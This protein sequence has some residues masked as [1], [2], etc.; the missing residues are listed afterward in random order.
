MRHDVESIGGISSAVYEVTALGV[1]RAATRIYLREMLRVNRPKYWGISENLQPHRH[2][3]LMPARG[4]LGYQIHPVILTR[5]HAPCRVAEVERAA[6]APRS[7]QLPAPRFRE[8]AFPRPSLRSE[9]RR[10]G[11][12]WSLE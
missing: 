11:K 6:V 12:E 5:F 9:E 1:M 4:G 8:R 3:A 2:R 10:V 7:P